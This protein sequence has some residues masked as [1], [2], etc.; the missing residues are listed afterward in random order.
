MLSASHNPIHFKLRLISNYKDSD[1]LEKLDGSSEQVI[2]LFEPKQ[3]LL[4]ESSHVLRFNLKLKGIM[5]TRI[6]VGSRHGL[7]HQ[8]GWFSSLMD[9]IQKGLIVDKILPLTVNRKGLTLSAFKFPSR[10]NDVCSSKIQSL[11]ITFTGTT[12]S[13]SRSIAPLSRPSLHC[14]N[15]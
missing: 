11:S 14:A 8:N 13:L 6:S 2:H 15:F 5:M 12:K 9:A 10:L 3:R 7:D 4:S 1:I